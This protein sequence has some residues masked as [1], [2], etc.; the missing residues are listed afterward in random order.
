MSELQEQSLQ[1]KPLS[2]A[3]LES[4]AEVSASE[5]IEALRDYAESGAAILGRGVNAQG[6]L[7]L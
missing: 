5:L 2:F 3:E 6:C 4:K 7:T 1:E